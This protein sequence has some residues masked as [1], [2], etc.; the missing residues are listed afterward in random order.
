ML[1]LEQL[2]K[3]GPSSETR[4][5]YGS[6]YASVDRVLCTYWLCLT[7]CH[8]FEM[9]PLPKL[10]DNPYAKKNHADQIVFDEVGAQ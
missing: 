10:E 9:C 1:S 2:A 3:L 5:V 8:E 6:Y 7:N 4:C